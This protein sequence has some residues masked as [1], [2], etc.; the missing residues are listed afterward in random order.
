MSETPS[1]RIVS[2]ERRESAVIATINAKMLD[3][4]KLKE[5]STVVDQSAND[6][7]V[8]LFIVDLARVQIVPSL[9]LGLLL[10]ISQK[11]TTHNQRFV[12]AGLSAG[13]R[14]TFTITKLDRILKLADNVDAALQG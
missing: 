9:G 6:A 11:C 14:Q 3:D 5:L 7:G 12:L 1:P 13:V 4:K 8:S 2:V 10:R